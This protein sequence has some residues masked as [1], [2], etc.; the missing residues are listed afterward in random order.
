MKNEEFSPTPPTP[1]T[2]PHTQH[3][4][5]I[6]SQLEEILELAKKAG[7]KD[8][9]VYQVSASSSPVYF[10]ANHLK[11]IESSQSS[12]CAL[13]LW[14]DDR[15]GLAVGYGTVA[16]ETLVEKAIAISQLN[17]PET[18]E[19]VSHNTAVYPTSGIVIPTQNLVEIGKA[20]IALI[21]EQY[22]EVLCSAEL[23]SELE[24]TTLVNSQ[25]LY[26]QYSTIEHSFFLGAE[27]IRGEDFLAIYEG[28]DS[29]TEINY[30]PIVQKLTQRLHWAKDNVP[31]LQGKQP[32]LITANAADLLWD[33]VTSALSAKRVLEKSSPWS[34]KQ[35]EIVLSEM[36]TFAQ[37]P[38]L[39]GVICPFDDE[40]TPTQDLS[41]ITEGRLQEFYC[42]RTTARAL[43]KESTGNGF[44]PSLGHYPTPSLVNLTLNPGTEDL[45]SLSKKL[46]NGIIID[47]ILGGG[48]DISGDFSINLD[49]G[50]RV[51]D[52]EIIGRVK[53]TM[54]A[55]N[56]YEALKQVIAL[57][58]DLN[59]SGFYRTPS[60]IVD[61]LSLTSS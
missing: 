57:G 22:P 45:V 37:R 51:A 34:E 10:E 32:V 21:R 8:A 29:D 17:L 11:Q 16:P 46:D 48:P 27:L 18:P 1:P 2:L 61:G 12:G 50:Y 4:I 25:G 39:P 55:G 60:I 13:R 52:G 43:G 56:V 36:L 49:L 28:E 9:E 6:N 3:P 30:L 38:R 42:D 7:A 23:E 15:P 31:S 19:L 24:T 33:I 35:G 58:N 53:D 5:M 26:C 47:Q 54:V 41:L 40:G 14:H 44:R 20:A 59:T